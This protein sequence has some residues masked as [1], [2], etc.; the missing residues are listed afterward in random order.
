[1]S[2]SAVTSVEHLPTAVV[3]HIL[4][5]DLDK[6]GVESL[7][8]AFDKAR[9][10]SPSLS[11]V[12]DMARVSFAGSM[13]LGVL[14]GL[15]QEFRARNQRLIFV[16]LHPFMRQAFDVTRVKRLLEIMADV[17]AALTSLSAP[18]TEAAPAKEQ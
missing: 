12:L 6:N 7:C 18:A 5:T 13:A 2:E 16:N 4:I 14:V 3:V 1:M 8:A 11:F 10:V 15:S 9:V 17:P